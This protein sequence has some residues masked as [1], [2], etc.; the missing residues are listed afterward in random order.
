MISQN[1][2]ISPNLDWIVN[3]LICDIEGNVILSW[4]SQYAV[5]TKKYVGVCPQKIQ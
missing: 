4:F 3:E 1:F 2:N 5:V